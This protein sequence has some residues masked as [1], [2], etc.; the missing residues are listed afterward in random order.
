MIFVDL[1]PLFK[2][3]ICCLDGLMVI[4]H[5]LLLCL[6]FFF[7]HEDCWFNSL[8]QKKSKPDFKNQLKQRGSQRQPLDEV[9]QGG[10]GKVK[11]PQQPSLLVRQGVLVPRLQDRRGETKVQK[12]TQELGVSSKEMKRKKQNKNQQQQN[13]Q[14]HDNYDNLNNL[15][16]PY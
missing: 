8:R 3:N 7:N 14:K 4:P 11:H 1:C 6:T 10:L 13:R 5:L 12:K 9:L 2:L 16:K 15:E